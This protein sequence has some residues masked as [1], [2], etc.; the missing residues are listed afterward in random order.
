MK[1]TQ[2]V[3]SAFENAALKAGLMRNTRKTYAATIREFSDMLKSG[4]VSG[5]QEYLDHLATVKK[6]PPNSVCHALNPLKFLYEKVIGKEFGQY[7]VP[8][9]NRSKP[10]RSVLTMLE[11]MGMMS[12]MDRIPRLQ[13]GLLAG[14]GLRIESDMLTLR[15]KDIRLADRVI[16]IYEAKGGK[17]RAIRIPEFLVADLETQITAC[18]KQW[19]LDK[20]KGIV[21]PHPQESLMRK[22]GRN[23][24]GT[25][26]WYWLF[27]SRKVHG[28][29]RW[30]STDK[31]LVTALRAAAES[32]GITQRVNPHALRHSFATGLLRNGV[33]LRSIQEQMG[34]SSLDTT[35]LYLH[36]SGGNTV[37]SP[38]DVEAARNLIPFKQTA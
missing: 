8:K 9:R 4:L 7:D 31:R 23:T 26:P 38:L 22:F 10:V 16:T 30:H 14:C 12:T 24:F 20:A 35:E 27:P 28:T 21:C 18:R 6:L 34:H 11:I 32:Q 37:Q 15:L 5:V 3:L 33:D 2:E 29:E 36:T 19:E 25:L 1:T 17:S 13:S